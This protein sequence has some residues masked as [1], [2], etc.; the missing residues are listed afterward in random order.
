VQG[1]SRTSNDPFLNVTVPQ[2]AHKIRVTVEDLA[3]RGGPFYGYRLLARRQAQDFQLS[4]A[5]P[6]VNVPKGGTAMILVAVNR[7]GYD[8]PIQLSVPDLPKGIRAEGGLIPREYMDPNNRFSNSRRGVLT[9][10]AEPGVEMS[11]RELAIFGQG[12]ASD[13]SVL[14]RRALG[15]GM[16]VEVAGATAQ[17]VV[18]RQRDLTAPWLGFELPAA[19]SDVPPATLEV[20]Q[21]GFKQ[22]EEGARYEFAYRWKLYQRDANVPRNLDVEIVG[23]RDIRPTEMNRGMPDEEGVVTG[24]FAVNTT[25]VTEA[26]RYDLVASGKLRVGGRDERVFARIIPFEVTQGGGRAVVASGR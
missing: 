24:T 9:L 11:A 17:G 1:T 10:T 8:G 19:L 5:T 20:R 18:D 22:M 14:K 25:K 21:T 23:A 13:G 15:S 26:G 4:I 16:E 6:Y 12:K 2:D 7:H 3:Q